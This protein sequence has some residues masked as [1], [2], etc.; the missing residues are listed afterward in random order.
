[1]SGAVA[2]IDCPTVTPAPP[3][4]RPVRRSRGATPVLAVILAV[5]AVLLSACSSGGSKTSP[6]GGPS[7][8]AGSSLPGAPSTTTAGAG[9]PTSTFKTTDP[10]LALYRFQQAGFNTG[11]AEKGKQ[12]DLYQATVTAGG[13]LKTKV[14]ELVADV[15]LTLA[16]LKKAVDGTLAT[17]DSADQA[18]AAN[19]L[20]AYWKKNCL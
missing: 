20:D 1:M 5:P 11:M 15:D 13:D 7:L 17:T 6:L 10:C 3:A 16:L 12:Q 4:P 9:G 2:A 14:P 8:P 19:N 18:K